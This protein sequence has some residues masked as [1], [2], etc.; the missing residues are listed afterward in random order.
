[1]AREYIEAGDNVDETYGMTQTA[2]HVA[3]NQDNIEMVRL[4]VDSRAN[5]ELETTDRYLEKPLHIAC[6]RGNLPIVQYLIEHVSLQT[7]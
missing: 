3:C 5:L 7:F 2:L 6:R 1:M 4:L